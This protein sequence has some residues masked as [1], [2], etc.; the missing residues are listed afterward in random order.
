MPGST[1]LL[2]FAVN[3]PYSQLTLEYY[4]RAIQ[5]GKKD[6]S[7]ILPKIHRIETRIYNKNPV[8]VYTTRNGDTNTQAAYNTSVR[9]G[10][11]A[12]ADD[13]GFR[14]KFRAG[15]PMGLG[16]LPMWIIPTTPKNL[17]PKILNILNQMQKLREVKS[18]LMTI[19]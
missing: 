8:D 14:D 1:K 17:I 16:L 18:P 13:Q 3:F 2:Q 12:L 15:L 4:K 7:I 5:I 6:L 9:R 11:I 19:F 10:I